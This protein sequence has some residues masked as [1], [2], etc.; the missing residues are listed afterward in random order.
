M[1]VL[2]TFIKEILNPLVPNAPFLYPLKTSENRK[3]LFSGD[4]LTENFIFC[5]VKISVCNYL[6]AIIQISCD[7]NSVAN[8]KE[9]IHFQVFFCINSKN[10]PGFFTLI[11]GI[12][13]IS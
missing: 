4:G 10:F 3:I 8:K 9:N 13:Q 2:F 11:F 7:V 6:L 1:T 12:N 5:E